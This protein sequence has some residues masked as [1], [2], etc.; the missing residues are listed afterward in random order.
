VNRVYLSLNKNH[1]IQR[2]QSVYLLLVVL[3]SIM[4]FFMPVY[5][6]ESVE[7][8]H[9]FKIVFSTLYVILNLVIAI[10]ALI[11]IFLYKNR[12]LQVKL[13]NLNMLLI[14]IFV[15]AIFYFAPQAKIDIDA[16]V[17]YAIGCYF[18]LVQLAFTF[19]AIRAIRKDE[20]LVRSADRLR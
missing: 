3:L 8:P 1:M 12:N 17:N 15:G 6:V 2:I 5:S 9:D 14:C 11:T 18:P 16:R 4:L 10:L 19:L 7:K 20:Q 13:S